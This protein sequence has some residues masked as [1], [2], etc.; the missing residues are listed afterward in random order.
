MLLKD[1]L[2]DV[3]GVLET[4]GDMEVR[5]DALITD[6]REKT[7]GGLFFCIS[8]ARFDAH[9]FVG[10]AEKNGCGAFV[11]ERI[12]EADVPQVKM[13]NVRSAMAYIA[14]AFYGHPEKEI[15][16]VGV[17]GTKGK[18]T[19]SYLMKAILEKAGFKT[20]LIGTTG[21]MIGEKRLHSNLTTPDP[22]DLHRCL[23]QM[24]DEGV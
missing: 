16:M 17:C 23:R 3:P 15:R 5:I 1:L 6:S 4:K 18:T 2:V 9:T 14:A 13:E 20:G 7:S 10:Q 21:N 8:G 12:L 24:R 11:V 19:T 22:I